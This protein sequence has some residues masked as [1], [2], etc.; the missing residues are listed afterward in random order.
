MEVDGERAFL[1]VD[2]KIFFLGGGKQKGEERKNE[3]G[4]LPVSAFL[5]RNPFRRTSA[6]DAI[7]MA[8]EDMDFLRE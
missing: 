6:K 8:G 7:F 5:K 2:K 3:V 4:K 1:H